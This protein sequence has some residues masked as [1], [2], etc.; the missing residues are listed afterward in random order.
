MTLVIMAAGMGSRFGGPKQIAPILETGEFTMD[1]AIYDAIRCGFSKIVLIIKKD[2]EEHFENTVVKR[3][4]SKYPDVK[5][6]LAFQDINDLP[7]PFV[8]P[9]T[10]LKP[11]GTGHAILAAKN[12]ITENFIVINADDFYGREAFR[13]VYDYLSQ[14]DEN[15]AHF[16]MAGYRLKNTLS[17]N[18]SVARGV[19]CTDK[20]SYL[21]QI[22][23]NLKIMRDADGI[24]RSRFDDGSFT[25]LD[26][27]TIV[28]MN[29]FGFT[30]KF[31]DYLTSAFVTFLKEN[32]NEPK[33]EYLLPV[34]VKN[35]LAD[36]LCDVKVLDT[37]AKWHGVT[38]LED[39]EKF[40]AAIENMIKDG[41]YPNGLWQ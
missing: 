9:K 36:G 19:C 35:M 26:E 6:T 21:T 15:S 24:I 31:L 4:K 17:E 33:K 30:P 14:I 1:F 38:Y 16:C 2:F 11:W 40:R 39:M 13:G 32:I 20:N 27:D 3:V 8:T 28:S 10:R 7:A 22:D 18:G 37:T 12:A 29:C 41:K 34:I 23:E 5:I 25:V